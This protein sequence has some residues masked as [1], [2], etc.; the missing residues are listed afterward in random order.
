ML[1]FGNVISKVDTKSHQQL[2][3]T[4]F[5]MRKHSCFWSQPL[6]MGIKIEPK[7]FSRGGF[8][9]TFHATISGSNKIYV[10]KKVFTIKIIE[11]INYSIDSK[12][13]QESFAKR[14]IQAHML[15]KNF[16]DQM[17][18][19]LKEID[20]GETLTYSKPMLGKNN[21]G[22]I[23]MIE[24]FIPGSFLK[25]VNNDGRIVVG[26]P[27][28]LVIKAECLARFSLVKSEEELRLVDIQGCGYELCDP[29]IASVQSLVGTKNYFRFS[30]GNMS[31]E[32]LL[33]FKTEHEC[34]RFCKLAN[35]EDMNEMYKQDS[36]L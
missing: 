19:N 32:A 25:Y 1:R 34:N 22:E 17:R 13:T 35:L 36:K 16:A 20:F 29:Q 3:V 2:Y 31:T 12:E 11:Q 28:E 18:S 10:V 14:A 4:E 30:I 33:N 9:E 24:E 6:S 21:I 15:A 8:R 7:P 23:I 26:P 5:K 27:E